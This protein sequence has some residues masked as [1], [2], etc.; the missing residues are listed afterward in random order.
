M[1]DM[2]QELGQQ[3]QQQQ[4]SSNPPG[5]GPGGRKPELRG[6]PPPMIPPPGGNGRMGTGPSSVSGNWN[7]NN[8]LGDGQT[9]PSPASPLVGHVIHKPNHMRNGVDG[10]GLIPYSQQR[11][12]SGHQNPPPDTRDNYRG[13]LNPP[14]PNNPSNDQR[15][16]PYHRPPP[17]NH[18]S[19]DHDLRPEW[20]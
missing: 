3:Q 19:T 13:P 11:L 7:G 4:Q 10:G 17:P 9:L 12:A 16:H 8:H 2:S 18:H 5:A 20:R 14:Y 15:F 6:T 1:S